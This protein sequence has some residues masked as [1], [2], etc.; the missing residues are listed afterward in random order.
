MAFSSVAGGVI[1]AAFALALG[2]NNSQIGIL[3]A[4]PPLSQPLQLLAIVLVDKV[5]RRKLI[6]VLTW[7]PAQAIWI[8]IALIPVLMNVPSSAAVSVMLGLMTLRSMLSAF[9]GCAWNS[10]IKDLVP[11]DVLGRFFAKR[12]MFANIAGMVMGLGAAFFADYWQKNAA[13]GD[14]IL[15]YTIAILVSAIFLG[16]SSPAIMMRIPEPLMQ[17]PSQPQASLTST[18]ATPINDRNYRQLLN[19]LLVQGFYM[20]LVMPFFVIYMLERLGFTIPMV[21]GLSMISLTANIFFLQLWGGFADRFGNKTVLAA[22]A[23][24]YLLTVL[25]WTFT[26]MPEKY[27]LTVPLLVILHILAGIASA[28]MGLTTST[29]TMKLAPQGQATAY[30]AIAGLAT[31]LGAATGSLLGGAFAQFFATRELFVNILWVDAGDTSNLPAL[32]FT[33][34]DFLFGIAFVIGLVSLSMLRSVREEGEVEKEVLLD[35]LNSPM[36]ELAR[37][38]SSIPGIN[39]LTQFPFGYLRRVPIPGLDVAMG[40]TA[41][42]IAGTARLATAVALKGQQATAKI[43]MTLE[44]RLSE[45]GKTAAK[46]MP[47]YQFEVARHMA[48][49]TMHAASEAAADT[50]GLFHSTLSRMLQAIRSGEDP[51]EVA[52]GTGFGSVQGA[53]EAGLDPVVAST[54]AL[55]AARSAARKTG[56]DEDFAATQTAIGALQAAQI[57][58]TEVAAKVKASLPAEIAQ[59]IE[60]ESSPPTTVDL[61]PDISNSISKEEETNGH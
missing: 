33:G 36:R 11:Q 30:L 57:I 59:A 51:D 5:K 46:A 31:S 15:G 40:V 13:P 52:R 1:L 20:G 61:S 22:T 12:Q 19:F 16:L 26:T 4:I 47:Y 14:E 54:I 23:S 18:L 10:W 60:T 41:H 3:A 45:I 53:S 28:G 8:L 7:F 58:G 21:M 43:S 27:F 56:V 44:D 2:A 24:L 32:S 42:Q 55:E 48:R 35:T 50:R 9:T 49:G 39:Y 34:F 38:V 25:G 37:P 17:T 6:A 29:L